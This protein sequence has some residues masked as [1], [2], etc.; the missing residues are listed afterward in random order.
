MLDLDDPRWNEL[1]GGYRVLYDPRS[2]LSTLES[3]SDDEEAWSEFWNNLHHQGDVDEAS[4]AVVPH[5]VRI[6]KDRRRNWQFYALITTIE[7]ERHKDRNPPLPDWLAKSYEE[8]IRSLR[9]LVADD[10]LKDLDDL[11]FQALYGAIAA[12]R[13]NLVRAELMGSFTD[14]ELQE[15]LQLYW[16]S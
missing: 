15:M 10:L 1:K 6:F 3:N 16:E 5:L 7:V 4:Y 13:G 14:D 12:A 11:F 8:A 9:A 2:A